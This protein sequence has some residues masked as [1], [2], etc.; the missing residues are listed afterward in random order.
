MIGGLVGGL[1][2]PPK[3]PEIIG[4][5]LNELSIQTSTYG[6]PIPHDYGNIAH[7]GNIIWLL[8]DKLTETEVKSGG[9][10]GAF[11]GGATSKTFT[12]S[13]S[14]AVGFSQRLS[15]PIFGIKRMWIGS[16][17]FIDF[18]SMDF[19]TVIKSYENAKYFTLYSGSGDQLPD[20]LIQMDR[21][22]DNTPAYTGLV[23]IV[24]DNLPL[25]DYGNSLL[26]AQVK[27][28]F[29]CNG[30]E[31]FTFA[32]DQGNFPT[33]IFYFLSAPYVTPTGEL[34]VWK[35]SD[36]WNSTNLPTIS[37]YAS[38]FGGELIFLR[39]FVANVRTI[40]PFY[41]PGCCHSK[42]DID[43]LCVPHGLS[44]GG[45]CIIYNDA[46]RS[47]KTL[48]HAR[49]SPDN[50]GADFCHISAGY[51]FFAGGFVSGQAPVISRSNITNSDT[52]EIIIPFNAAQ[53]A[54]FNAFGLSYDDLIAIINNADDFSIPYL[55]VWDKNSL[56]LKSSIK[57]STSAYSIYTPDWQFSN[58]KIYLR[59]SGNLV[60]IDGLL[61]PETPIPGPVTVNTIPG[62]YP[63][64]IHDLG[65]S[66]IGQFVMNDG[67]AAYPKVVR[68]WIKQNL[69]NSISLASII[70]QE[71]L[72]SNL[73]TTA[74]I[75]VTELSDT[76]RGYQVNTPGAIRGAIEPLR[77]AFPFDVVMSGYKIKFKKRG[78]V[79]V[80]TI[81][82][83][84][85]DA[86][87]AG[88][89]TGVQITDSREMDLMMSK[90]VSLRYLDINREYEANQQYYE[91]INTDAVNER[92][93]DLPIV[94]NADE[95]SQRAEVLL[96]IY[97]MERHD[98]IF[99]LP[100]D[101]A[102]LEPADI[103]TIVSD[104]T[105]YNLRLTS[106]NTRAD[107]C[108]E[109]TAKYNHSPLYTASA[110]GENGQSIGPVLEMV[111]P[112]RY[113][114]LD[115]P[116]LLDSTNEPGF[117]AALNGYFSRWPGGVLYKSDDGGMLWNSVAT[118][119]NP[120]S[121]IGYATGT[122]STHSGTMLD[123][124]S[125]LPVKIYRGSLFTITEA[126][127]F[128]GQN[129]FAYGLD[130]RWEIIA[131]Q[132]CI[133]Q[134]D[135]S[136]ILSD[137]MRGQAGTEWST[138]LHEVDDAVILLDLTQLDFISLNSSAI[139]VSKQYRGIT[140]GYELDS[141]PGT[142]FTYSG[143]NLKCLSPAQLTGSRHPSTNDWTLTW[144]Y[145]SRF[146][147]WR[148]YVDAVMSEA[149]ESYV[150]ELW[151]SSGTYTLLIKTYTATTPNLIYT[152]A[153][154]VA[155]YGSNQATLYL[156]IYQVSEVTGRGYPLQISITR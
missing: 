41:N 1:I 16:S 100:P 113:E 73:I 126:Q 123:K 44:G 55:V 3:T 130:S 150:I 139:G 148:D 6:A 69:T 80:V 35:V 53:G 81:P 84:N 47:V 30:E 83:A 5:R 39:K 34:H 137:F 104:T 61:N 87:A 155:D 48:Y 72:L 79:S 132:T 19:E 101:Y 110:L 85:L 62:I 28:E 50:T 154:Q 46:F 128:A 120:G 145:R 115:I 65:G 93:Y 125:T 64:E 58:N 14:F 97:W 135:G 56:V 59:K 24:F 20:P 99:T 54:Q 13:A 86:R 138:G 45:V 38:Y 68:S 98:V 122:L 152:S 67:T 60:Y 116:V 42:T 15:G 143:T 40:R 7:T 75:D 4:P 133:L 144:V 82:L 105:T 36:N 17:V 134:V 11:G 2:D 89:R 29:I 117:L 136:Y 43:V 124:S 27:V 21:G 51:A 78:G 25:E 31:Q 156:K 33:G 8:N 151:N 129:W 106:V 95:A 18:E 49:P 131:A 32:N 66:L 70:T 103:I 94:F 23:Y 88:D 114:L 91:R 121:I 76:V 63:N 107:G 12:Y 26:G 147:G 153:Q 140:Y 37:L 90:K 9:K 142:V 96:Y 149:T 146:S 118:A 141:D 10:G 108:L 127:L 77:A 74:D 112:T 92:T 119:N 102:A 71:C 22:V 52:V 109:C 111:G 57:Y